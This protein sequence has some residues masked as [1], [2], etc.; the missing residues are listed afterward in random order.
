MCWHKR[1]KILCETYSQ[2]IIVK[3]V[4]C[5][6][7]KWG[8]YSEGSIVSKPSISLKRVSVPHKIWF[9]NYYL[10]EKITS[11]GFQLLISQSSHESFPDTAP[12]PRI[13]LVCCLQWK[14]LWGP[15]WKRL[16]MKLQ[17]FLTHNS[18][19]NVFPEKQILW[20]CVLLNY[21]KDFLMIFFLNLP[22]F[23]C[24][25]FKSWIW[26]CQIGSFSRRL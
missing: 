8:N 13:L 11:K 15:L 1:I 12:W 7:H 18:S 26:G 5:S 24:P 20:F 14:Q 17:L 6:Q 9:W 4:S 19:S 22:D 23:L 3:A 25:S 16:C 21:R 2:H 10:E